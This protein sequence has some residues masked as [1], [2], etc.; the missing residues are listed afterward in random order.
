MPGQEG[1]G[2]KFV[3]VDE[4]LGVAGITHKNES[5]IFAPEDTDTALAYGHR[6][7]FFL[8]AGCDERPLFADFGKWI[9]FYKI[10]W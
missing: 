6:V 9:K 8:V 4:F 3:R 1:N 2:E 10:K 5:N 7:G